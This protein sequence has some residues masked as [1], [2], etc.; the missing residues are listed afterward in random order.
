MPAT[1]KITLSVPDQQTLKEALDLVPGIHLECGAPKLQDDGTFAVVVYGTDA[2]ATALA[3]RT[4]VVE[5]DRD[6]ARRL[7]RR[8]KEVGVG[9]RFAGG[10]IVPTGRGTVTAR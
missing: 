10:T 3:R 4:G 8:R 7:A 9:D 5:I 2:D 1:V 6:I